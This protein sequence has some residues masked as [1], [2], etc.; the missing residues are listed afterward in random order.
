MPKGEGYQPDEKVAKVHLPIADMHFEHDVAKG[1]EDLTDS[2][3]A[4]LTIEFHILVECGSDQQDAHRRN[5][6]RCDD[7]GGNIRV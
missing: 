1:A 4:P 5:L 3:E 6:D 7:L 2:E